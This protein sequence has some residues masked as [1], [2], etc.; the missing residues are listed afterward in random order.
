MKKNI[1]QVQACFGPCL[2]TGD[3]ILKKDSEEVQKPLL[4]FSQVLQ[5]DK[6]IHNLQLFHIQIHK[7]QIGKF[8]QSILLFY[9]AQK[10]QCQTL[11]Q[12]E[13]VE[14]KQENLFLMFS[15]AMLDI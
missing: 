8:F 7:L 12:E 2:W 3:V 10:K 1:N 11:E 4:N 15:S 9:A 14:M 6:Q 13:E 5:Q